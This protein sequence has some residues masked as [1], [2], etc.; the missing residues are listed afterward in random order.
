MLA[1]D[2]NL[3]FLGLN[4]DVEQASG[5][6]NIDAVISSESTTGHILLDKF[7]YKT[8]DKLTLVDNVNA[9]IDLKNNKIS[10]LG[11]VVGFISLLAMLFFKDSPLTFIFAITTQTET[12]YDVN[13]NQRGDY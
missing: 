3:D 7:N 8:K 12:V 11:F 2:F 4:K 9:N 6:A 10:Y 5:I 13:K 1:K